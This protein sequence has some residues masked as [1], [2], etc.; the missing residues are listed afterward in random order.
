MTTQM[1]HEIMQAMFDNEKSGGV[2][3]IEND[4]VNKIIQGYF[5]KAFESFEPA[6]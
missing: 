4:K 3:Y 6:Y 2:F 1:I 5:P